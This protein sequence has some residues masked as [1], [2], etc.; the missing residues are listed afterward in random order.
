MD[1]N[2]EREIFISINLEKSDDALKFAVIAINENSVITAL[3]RIY[4]AVFYTVSALAIKNDFRTAK[5]ATMI[6]WFNKKFI[7]EEKVFDT[8]LQKIYREIFDFRQKGDYDTKLPADM[9]TVKKLLDSAK[10][11][12]ET[13]RKEINDK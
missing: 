4:Y 5:H 13:V 12:I 10:I 11:F 1:K 2:E 7:H 9:D 6:G 3:N 8:K